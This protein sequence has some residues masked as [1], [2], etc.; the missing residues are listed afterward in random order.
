MSRTERISRAENNSTALL[1]TQYD[2]FGTVGKD[3]Y[4]ENV[5]CKMKL[6]I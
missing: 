2:R 1:L 6:D 3:E 5:D 4:F